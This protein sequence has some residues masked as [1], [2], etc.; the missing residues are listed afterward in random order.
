MIN[1]Y[2]LFAVPVTHGKFIVPINLH[3]KILNHVDLNYSSSNYISCI[4]G[5]QIHNN[6]EGKK[7]LDILLN[8][9]FNNIFNL[10][11]IHGWLN[12]LGNKS[13]NNPHI[14]QGNNIVSSGILYL[15]SQNNNINFTKDSQVFQI[16]PKIFDFLLFP[17]T[18]VH[19]VLPEERKEKRIAYAFN[20]STIGE[21]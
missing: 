14:H 12:I 4:D 2:N 21:E 11:L 3:K 10:K 19:Y 5:H 16:K 18:L 13:Y 9:Y 8:N 20:L 7:E 1:T 17:N 15:S 6:F